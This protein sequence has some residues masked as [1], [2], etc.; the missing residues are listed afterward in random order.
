MSQPLPNA[1]QTSPRGL[2]DTVRIL[3]AC[4]EETRLRV[5]T[6]LRDS[7]L[8]VKD[9]TEILGQS[10]PRLSRHLKFLVE[11]GVVERHPEG[12]WAYFRLADAADTRVLAA[13]ATGMLDE[14]DR[15]IA[16]DRQRLENLRT[17]RAEKAANYF[18]Q[19]ARAWDT[20]RAL[21]IA[22]ERVEQAIV[23]AAGDH[24]VAEM[25]DM[26]TGTGRML[27]LFCNHYTRGIGIDL[28]T[29]MLAIA[30]A[31]LDKAAIS[32][33]QVRHGDICN[34]PFAPSSF[35]LVLIHHVLH[36]LEQPR[37][38]IEEAGRVLA[39]GGRLIVVD[40]APHDLEFLRSRYAHRRLGLD[41]EVVGTWLHAAGLRD[42]TTTHLA[43]TAND[44]RAALTVTIWSARD[45]RLVM[46][47]GT[48]AAQHR[49][50]SLA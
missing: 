6:L 47:A 37:R 48:A 42:V 26:G 25:L 28:S 5:L 30:R 9:L 16:T 17:A 15:I 13:A 45:P 41:D 50:R 21:H 49:G 24:P 29:R 14:N 38:A 4:G 7:E 40:F 20:I 8:S 22:D 10:Q 12:A 44:E 27:E 34:M 19:H 43:P 32:H 39:P 1:A 23:A 3:R 35:E 33:A 46:A 2:L 36:F 31:K 11:A 18:S